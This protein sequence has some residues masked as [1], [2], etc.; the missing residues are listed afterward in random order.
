VITLLVLKFLVIKINHNIIGLDVLIDSKFKPWILEVNHSPSFSTDSK[1]DREIKQNLIQ[2]TFQ[3]LNLNLTNKKKY[4]R[5][6]QVQ[7]QKRALS[8]SPHKQTQKEKAEDKQKNIQASLQKREEYEALN[9][10]NYKLIYPCEKNSIQTLKYNK[11]L[12]ASTNFW[13]E[14]TN[15]KKKPPKIEELTSNQKSIKILTQNSPQK[16]TPPPPHHQLPSQIQQQQQHN[17]NQLQNQNQNQNK[18]TQSLNMNDNKCRSNI[19]DSELNHLLHSYDSFKYEHKNDINIPEANLINQIQKIAQLEGSQAFPEFEKYVN[20]NDEAR[21]HKFKAINEFNQKLMNNYNNFVNTTINSADKQPQQL[22]NTGNRAIVDAASLQMY[23]Q[24]THQ[25]NSTDFQGKSSAKKGKSSKNREN[26]DNSPLAFDYQ[27][28]S[29]SEHTTYTDPD[30]PMFGITGQNTVNFI[31]RLNFINNCGK[32]P[33]SFIGNGKK[34]N[35]TNNGN[36]LNQIYV[37]NLSKTSGLGKHSITESLLKTLPPNYRTNNSNNTNSEILHNQSHS[38]PP[39]ANTNLH[40][41]MNKEMK[42]LI[43]IKV[44]EKYSTINAALLKKLESNISRDQF[45]RI[46]SQSQNHPT[47]FQSQRKEKDKE[48]PNLK[49]TE[50]KIDKEN[51]GLDNLDTQIKFDKF[52]NLDKLDKLDKFDHFD[53]NGMLETEGNGEEQTQIQLHNKRK[54]VPRSQIEKA[55]NSVKGI[56]KFRYN[57]KPSDQINNNLIKTGNPN[58]PT[59]NPSNNL[60]SNNFTPFAFSASITQENS[61]IPNFANPFISVSSQNKQIPLNELPMRVQTS[62]D[63]CRRYLSS[64]ISSLSLFIL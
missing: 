58:P 20:F 59:S 13:E 35:K 39:T 57:N 40:A 23:Y 64:N 43:S 52:A 18:I 45:E 60:N 29:T 53:L 36:G 44:N 46:R 27:R 25:P 17:Q 6:Q 5:R 51:E 14:F 22:C 15:G 3:L 1:F 38:K 50:I 41:N 12:E 49:E 30:A 31:R 33:E 24:S 62:H 32:R 21:A 54:P 47:R 28:K 10:G 34:A 61:K 7:I 4:K 55:R 56:R 42:N 37:E 9:R 19:R 2:D 48:K 11:F 63:P 16:Y 8:K 26:H